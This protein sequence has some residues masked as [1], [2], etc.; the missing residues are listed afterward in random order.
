MSEERRKAELRYARVS[1]TEQNLDLQ[2]D[3]LKQAGREKIT[4]HAA[5]GGNVHRSR[6]GLNRRIGYPDMS[7]CA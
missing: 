4:E 3:A 2:G 1:T 5:S 7:V 6:Y